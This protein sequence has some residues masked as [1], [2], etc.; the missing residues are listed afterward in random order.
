MRVADCEILETKVMSE[1]CC[2]CLE[3]KRRW[4]ERGCLEKVLVGV[5]AGWLSGSGEKG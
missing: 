5:G 3:E 4:M 1:M 2:V